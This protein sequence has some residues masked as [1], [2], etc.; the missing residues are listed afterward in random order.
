M[1]A[2]I[3]FG[4]LACMLHATAHAQSL[5]DYSSDHN[6]FGGFQ[7]LMP[8]PDRGWRLAS[9]PEPIRAGAHS[10]RFE[11]DPGDCSSADGQDDCATD[12]ERV[13]AEHQRRWHMGDEV[14]IAFSLYIPRDFKDIGPTPTHLV[15]VTQKDGPTGT[16]HDMFSRPPVA[17]ISVRDGTL[18]LRWYK[19]SGSVTDYTDETQFYRLISVAQLRGR[20]TDW[21]LHVRFAK[22]DGF[23]EVYMNGDLKANVSRDLLQFDAS[24]FGFAYGIYRSFVSRYQQ[25]FHA[26]PPRQ[27]VYFDEIRT[28]ATRSAVDLRSNANLEP[29]D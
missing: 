1:R 26:D 25:Q 21:L 28:G 16:V 19:V 5:N 2:L 13:Q 20:W 29:V 9:A 7:T 8:H 14:W 22:S 11:V 4:M 3:Y 23:L 12:R 27:V 15:A 17:H 24:S 6:G 10:Q 18:W